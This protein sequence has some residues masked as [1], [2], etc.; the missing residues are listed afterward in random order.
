MNADFKIA[1]IWLSSMLS[2]KP[3]HVHTVDKVKSVQLKKF[4]IM[5]TKQ[6]FFFQIL[7][8]L[9]LLTAEDTSLEHEQG[10]NTTNCGCTM[11]TLPH[12]RIILLEIYDFIR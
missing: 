11:E 8:Y 7:L 2:K 1:I 12:P 9:K 5:K 3:D 10:A 4:K 6:M